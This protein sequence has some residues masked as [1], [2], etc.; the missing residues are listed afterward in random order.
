LCGDTLIIWGS[1]TAQAPEREG[2]RLGRF[3]FSCTKGGHAQFEVLR[4]K[5]LYAT[6]KKDAAEQLQQVAT[7][8]VLNRTVL[9]MF[10]QLVYWC[11]LGLVEL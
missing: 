10:A 6:G 1:P 9:L 2:Q 8:R 7:K 4:H 3:H 5:R 11:T